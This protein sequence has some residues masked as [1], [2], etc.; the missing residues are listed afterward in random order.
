LENTT[1]IACYEKF[2]FTE[3]ATPTRIN[4]VVGCRFMTLRY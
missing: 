1:A 4:S 3:S 2:G